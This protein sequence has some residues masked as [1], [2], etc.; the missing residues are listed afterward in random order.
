[1]GDVDVETSAVREDVLAV[2]V[3]CMNAKGISERLIVTACGAQD[4]EECEQRERT[5]GSMAC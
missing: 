5:E 1:M 3:E 4:S 2:K